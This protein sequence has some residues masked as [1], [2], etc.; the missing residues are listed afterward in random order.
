MK[1]AEWVEKAENSKPWVI[2]VLEKHKNKS[3]ED[4]LNYEWLVSHGQLHFNI[5]AQKRLTLNERRAVWGCPRV[6]TAHVT[7]KVL[8]F[9]FLKVVKI[10]DSGT[11]TTWDDSSEIRQISHSDSHPSFHMGIFRTPFLIFGKRGSFMKG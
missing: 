11:G 10:A 2:H 3:G 9:R 5:L 1:K 6:K 4:P 8:S 7:L